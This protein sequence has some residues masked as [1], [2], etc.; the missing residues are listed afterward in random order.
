[1]ERMESS[2]KAQ[3][4]INTLTTTKF[5][6]SLFSLAHILSLTENLSRILQQKSVDKSKAQFLIND[7]KSALSN[8]REKAEACFKTIYNEAECLH[9]KMN[10]PLINDIP[11]DLN[12]RF[13]SYLFKALE[14]DNLLPSFII[15]KSDTEIEILAESCGEY[16]SKF[17]NE[18]KELMAASLRSEIEFWKIK[19]KNFTKASLP[20]S[21]SETL[22]L[23]DPNI[24]PKIYEL[25]KILCTLPVSVASAE[26]SFSS[27]KRLKSWLRST[28][29]QERLVGLALLHIHR[30]IKPCPEAVLNRFANSNK[31]ILDLVL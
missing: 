31:R 12:F 13:N 30:D 26:R 1:M 3:R 27:L 24:H 18:S 8:K 7:I 6:I 4:L 2:S 25:L 15:T 19:F 14:A 11:Q 9:K 22:P 17:T 5:I 20:N 21:A 29:G 16:L 28:M 23:C 10:I